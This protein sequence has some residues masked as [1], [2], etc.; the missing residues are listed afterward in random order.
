MFLGLRVISGAQP[1]VHAILQDEAVHVAYDNQIQASFLDGHVRAF[2]AIGGRA[3]RDAPLR[4]LEACGDPGRVGSGTV[5]AP[6]VRGA[7]LALRCDSFFCAPGLDGV[8]EKGGVEGEIGRFRRRHL[9]PVPHVGSLAALNKALAAADARDDTAGSA[10]GSRPSARP[11]PAQLSVGCPGGQDG[12]D[13]GGHRRRFHACRTPGWSGTPRRTRRTCISRGGHD[14]QGLTIQVED[15]GVGID[16][17]V[18]PGGRNTTARARASGGHATVVRR[19]S[20]EPPHLG[21]TPA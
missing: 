5:R 1:V 13:A 16:P 2:H 12:R 14:R 21:G 3:D 10:P 8:H 20:R 19:S 6:Q 7:A 9:T 17:Y 4:Q 15:N 11:P 18:T